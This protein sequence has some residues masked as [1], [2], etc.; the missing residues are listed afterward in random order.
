M[1]LWLELSSYMNQ[2]YV[3]IY[4]GHAI[5]RSMQT[6]IIEVYA[7]YKLYL[8][9]YAFVYGTQPVVY[10]ACLQ[11]CIASSLPIWSIGHSFWIYAWVE[12]TPGR[13]GS[14]QTNNS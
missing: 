2:I 13:P 12:E 9:I 8:R 11:C 5:I 4:N 14:H 10:P 3:Q 7:I 1:G 6:M